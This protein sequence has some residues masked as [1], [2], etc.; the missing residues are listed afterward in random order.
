MINKKENV[1][2][3]CKFNRFRSKVAE[4]YFNKINK[5]PKIKAKSA[6]IIR[7]SPINETQKRICKNSGIIIGGKPCGLSTRLLRWQTVTIIVANDVPPIIFKDNNKY[8]KKVLI[9]KIPDAESDNVA[10]IKKIINSIKI[11]ILNFINDYKN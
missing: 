4:S 5:N 2:F 9:W 6:G 10:E 11:N 8:G 1:L 3:I 7:G